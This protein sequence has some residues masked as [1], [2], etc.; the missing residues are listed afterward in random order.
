MSHLLLTTYLLYCQRKETESLS[1]D[2][3]FL[4]PEENR[5][6]DNILLMSDDSNG[7]TV[8]QCRSAVVLVQEKVT[9]FVV[10]FFSA[11]RSFSNFTVLEKKKK[12]RRYVYYHFKLR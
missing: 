3:V 10:K 9:P 1:E 8:L 12:C 2:N 7:V 6:I 11:T 5:K 4:P